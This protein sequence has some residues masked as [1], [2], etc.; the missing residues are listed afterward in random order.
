MGLTIAMQSAVSGLNAA[1]LALQI[2]SANVTNA[3]TPA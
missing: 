1:Q 2:T 3:N